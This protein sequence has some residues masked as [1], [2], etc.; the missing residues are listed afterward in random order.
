MGRV[1]KGQE[2]CGMCDARIYW[3]TDKFGDRV[4]MNI[5]DKTMHFL[6]CLFV[7]AARKKSITERMNSHG[8]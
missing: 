7:S 2:L 3:A 5:A 6:S 4:P 8:S 1:I